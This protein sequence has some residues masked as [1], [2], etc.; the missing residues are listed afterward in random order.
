[1]TASQVLISVRQLNR[2]F[3]ENIG[4]S[5]SDIIQRE[6]M[7]RIKYLLETTKMSIAD[8]S[9]KTGFSSEY[10]LSRFFKNKEG[11][12]PSRYREDCMK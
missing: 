4:M 3:V 8:I 6:K 9:E 1:M 5:I 10:S 12:P 2:L 7:K 11:I